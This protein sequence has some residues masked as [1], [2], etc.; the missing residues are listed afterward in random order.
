MTEIDDNDE[1]VPANNVETENFN[2]IIH[3][4]AN[5]NK[6]I[7]TEPNW[8]SEQWKEPEIDWQGK[9]PDPPDELLSPLQYFK[10]FIDDDIINNFVQQTNIYST[11]KSGKC[12]AVSVS[13]ME[14]FL[15]IKFNH[16]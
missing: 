4:V 2:K 9:L 13:E 7:I 10:L 1:I 3:E 11:E 12:I 6:T 14:Q 16:H 15:G 8:I 5:G